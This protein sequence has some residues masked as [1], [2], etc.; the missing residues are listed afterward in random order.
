MSLLQSFNHIS[1]IKGE[2]GLP[3]DKSISH[4]AV[5]FSCL[6]K[7]K[8]VLKNLSPGDDVRSSLNCFSQLGVDIKK[9]ETELV[10]TGKGFKGLKESGMPLNAGNSGTLARLITGILSVQD[11]QS[12]IIGDKSLSSRPMKRIIVP[13]TSMGAKITSTPDS[14]LPLNIFPPDILTPIKYELPVASAQ[15]KGSVLMAGL[16]LDGITTVIENFP[17]RDHTEKML[18]LKTDVRS[19][20]YYSYVSRDNYPESKEYFIPG[21]ISTA[22]FFI[23]LTLLTKNSELLIKDVS[24]NT[25][26]TGILEILSKMG[27]DIQLLNRKENSGEIYGDILVRS[28]ELKNI[29]LSDYPVVNFIDEIP[30]LAIAGV[31]AEG[32]FEIRSAKEL[33]FKESDRIK[34]V[35]ENL[36]TTG[37]DIEEFEDGFIISGRVKY[38]KP[39]FTSYDDHRIA[40][41]FGILSTLLEDGGKVNNFDC[42]KISNPGFL[43]QLNQVSHG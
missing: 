39:E 1:R 7:G 32:D 13:L 28:S 20:K 41:A 35:C 6:A 11:F 15:V 21:D 34:A 31:F 9:K 19:G 24:L 42:V 43:N 10:I 23:I 27:G 26:R 37:L 8:S 14:T 36:R 18:N 17:S 38:K 5:M 22:V 2:L 30:V 25:S 16:H 40:M 29:D 3:G 12:I 33:R 4:R